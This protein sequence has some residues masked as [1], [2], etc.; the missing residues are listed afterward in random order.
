MPTCCFNPILSLW[1]FLVKLDTKD[2]GNIK[3]AL[4]TN[5]RPRSIELTPIDVPGLWKSSMEWVNAFCSW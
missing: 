5:T 2:K 4:P 1:D 3:A